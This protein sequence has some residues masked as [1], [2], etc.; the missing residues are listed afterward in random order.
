M[1]GK[2]VYIGYAEIASKMTFDPVSVSA[3]VVLAKFLLRP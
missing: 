2:L 1:N 3:N